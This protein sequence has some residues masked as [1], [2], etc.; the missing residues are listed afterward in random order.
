M[1]IQKTILTLLCVLFATASHGASLNTIT[2]VK[3]PARSSDSW[4]N[5]ADTVI[6]SALN[7]KLYQ[8]AS[9]DPVSHPNQYAIAYGITWQNL[10]YSEST[11]M[12]N[13]VLNPNPP[14][15]NEKGYV[16]MALVDMRSPDG[17]DSISLNDLRVW[18]KSSDGGVLDD[19]HENSLLSNPSNLERPS[20][21]FEAGS[22]ALPGPHMAR[23]SVG[24]NSR[25]GLLGS[26]LDFGGYTPRAIAVRRD[27]TIINSGSPDQKGNRILLIVFSKLFNGGG[28]EGGL[29][30]VRN[31][32]DDQVVRFRDYNLT[33]YAQIKGN[34]VSV[35]SAT[36]SVVGRAGSPQI[37]VQQNGLITLR[38][39][40][41][42]RYYRI[43]RTQDLRSPANWQLISVIRGDEGFFMPIHSGLPAEFFRVQ[44]Q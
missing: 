13:G 1:N 4:M 23:A 30:G 21:S 15:Q 32:V 43:Y 31:W 27:G 6:L 35:T 36:V 26:V 5:A 29:S 10:V 9:P 25:V 8:N 11:S 2:P 22:S 42:D 14:F 19:V 40:F 39:V 16:V 34:D 17:T 24:K 33:F 7:G 3:M 37:L 20:I 41:S 44:V 12:W 38:N 28:S 18:F